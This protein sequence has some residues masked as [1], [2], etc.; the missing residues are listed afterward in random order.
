MSGFDP[1]HPTIEKLSIADLI[2]KLFA[3]RG[4][5]K[6]SEMARYRPVRGRSE[7]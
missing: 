3:L 7:K 2:I 4:I 5:T 1:P 6:H